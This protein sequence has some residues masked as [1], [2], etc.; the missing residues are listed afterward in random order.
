MRSASQS[1][2]AFR[3]ARASGS[4]WNKLPFDRGWAIETKILGTRF[5]KPA[6]PVIDDW[7]RSRGVA[8]S[9]KSLDLTAA[10]YQTASRLRSAIT[11]SARALANFR[12]ANFG[13]VEVANSDIKKRVL[14]YAFEQ[15]A[16]TRTQSR[17]LR[18]LARELKKD[19]GIDLVFQWIP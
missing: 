11:R 16:V 6:F 15:G 19:L 2:S 14:V 4:V 8:T 7:V 18:Q 10:S 13:G 12:G 17:A 3:A 1:V 9:I 5:L